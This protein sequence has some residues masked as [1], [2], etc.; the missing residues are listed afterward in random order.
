VGL[1][2][3][4]LITVTTLVLT[5][6][7]QRYLAVG[8]FWFLGTLVP[9]LGLIQVGEQAM[10]DRYAYQSFIGLFLIVS[11]GAAE[12]AASWKLSRAPLAPVA[13][14]VI[15]ALSFLTYRQV[16]YW[17]DA[18]T[19]WSHALRVTPER[20]YFLHLEL[21]NA[22]DQESRFDEAIP[23]LRAAVD[24][25]HPE[26]HQ[27]VHLGFGI[28]DQRHGHV[29]EA[30]AEYQTALLLSTDPET[31]ADTYSD[32]GSAYRQI[33]NYEAARQ[34]F[35]AA[36]QIDANQSMA[37]IGMGLLAQKRGDLSGAI[38]YYSVAMS[39]EPTDVGYILLAQVEHE[40]GHEAEAQAAA[41]KAAQLTTDLDQARQTA[42]ALLAF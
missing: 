5:C 22:L 41:E 28:Y 26:E 38:R 37:L 18:I 21:G 31:R 40:A 7:R 4:L 3:L 39:H 10:A 24:P 16:G 9:M 42:A 17:H 12:L 33:R 20:P 6:R 11:W 27:L 29:Q 34:S 14:S 8:W 32:L 35:A 15:L 30:I 19:L 13:V 1:S 25:N 36:L 23:E 2:A